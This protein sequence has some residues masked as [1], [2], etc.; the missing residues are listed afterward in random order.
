MGSADI[1]IRTEGLGKKYQIGGQQARYRTLRETLSHAA[2]RPIER[3]RHPGAATHSS[4][5]F[6]AL[7]DVDL[8][9]E[10]GEVLGVI[11]RNGAGKSTLLKILSHITEPSEG[12]AV[13]AGR[14]ASL[15]EVGTG[16]HSELTGRENIML[17]GAI[18]G[19]TRAEIRSRFEEIVEF[20]EIGRFLD[21]P[22]KRYS[23]G[24]YVRLAF[25]VAAHLEPEI[26][27]IDEVLAVGDAEFQK[28]CLGKMSDVAQGGRTVVFVSHNMA[29]VNRLC[30][31]A[32]LLDGGRLRASGGVAEITALY[33]R[34]GGLNA[35]E[36][37]WPDL[38]AAPGDAVVRLR[39]V[40]VLQNGET[41][42]TVEI[43][44]PVVIEMDYCCLGDGAKLL[45]IFS[46]FDE[47]GQ[48]A[49]VSGDF[50]RAVTDAEHRAGLHTCRCE[51]P[52]N[53]FSEGTMSVAAEVCTSHPAYHMH[54]LQREAVSFQVVDSGVPGNVRNEWGRTIL[55]VVRPQLGWEREY[56]GEVTES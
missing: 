43:T 9:V 48:L 50:S 40:R 35:A 23:S 47:Q 11:G 18:L 49:F 5:E 15:L 22:V 33:L 27:I 10:L 52:G 56:I 29:A 20:S 53:L 7:K 34:G 24:M 28:K 45:P 32:V 14:V 6:W 17:N 26:L 46:F 37:E 1:V 21:T 31:A 39:A 2:R 54:F 42:T 13:I 44:Q 36:Q 25:A 55:G 30:T 51:V 19:M 41:T 12:R 3:L 4:E 16:F 8:T 38:L